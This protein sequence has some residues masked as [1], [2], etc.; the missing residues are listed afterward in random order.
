MEKVE[1]SSLFIRS[2][3]APET[4]L[5]RARATAMRALSAPRRL[6]VPLSQ[7]PRA[8]GGDLGARY[9]GF[10][11]VAEGLVEVPTVEV[12][13]VERRADAEVWLERRDD[14]IEWVQVRAVLADELLGG[15][16]LRSSEGVSLPQPPA[17]SA[18]VE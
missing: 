5:F 4:G 11:L 14:P 3:E 8:D 18:Y 6:E 13:A 10:L 7:E 12:G 1:S 17:G 9:G 2:R 15:G 16:L